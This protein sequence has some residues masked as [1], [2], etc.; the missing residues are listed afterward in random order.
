ML[1]RDAGPD[2]SNAD[3]DDDSTNRRRCRRIG[4]AS[5]TR[6]PSSDPIYSDP[7]WTPRRRRTSIGRNVKSE[8]V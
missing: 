7:S 8:A 2:F 3:C 1:R 5:A 4:G 6:Q